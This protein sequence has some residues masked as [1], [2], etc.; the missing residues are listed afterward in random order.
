MN[1]LLLC[2]ILTLRLTLVNTPL[3]HS[4]WLCRHCSIFL[5]VHILI[6]WRIHTPHHNVM[7]GNRWGLAATVYNN[8]RSFIHIKAQCQKSFKDNFDFTKSKEFYLSH[9]QARGW[10]GWSPTPCPH[11][12]RVW[13]KNG[14]PLIIETKL[15]EGSHLKRAKL[16]RKV[17]HGG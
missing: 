2:I 10:A 13:R 1:D 3:R 15:Y 12:L 14:L 11:F 5:I 8:L 7:R 16:Q 17:L 4:R 9:P 6:V